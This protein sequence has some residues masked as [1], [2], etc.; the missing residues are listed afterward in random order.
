MSLERRRKV[1]WKNAWNDQ[2]MVPEAY[3]KCAEKRWGP[4]TP[5]YK[6]N[7][8]LKRWAKEEE[9]VKE[10]PERSKENQEGAMSQ[11]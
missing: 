9:H 10:Q 1:F 2:H 3:K 6:R 11:A 5:P 8:V 7:K 4:R